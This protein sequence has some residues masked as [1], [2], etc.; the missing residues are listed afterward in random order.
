[1]SHSHHHTH[2]HQAESNLKTAFWLNA[3]FAIIEI[4]G[5]IYTNSIAI[6]SDAFHDLGDSAALGLAWYFQR[7]SSK[8]RDANYSYGYKRFS[9]AGAVSSS[10]IL[11]LGSV[12]IISEA[13]PRLFAP[14]I[15]N[16]K[17]M[18]LLAVIGIAVNSAAMFKLKKGRSQNEKMI[19]LHLLEDVLGWVAVLVAGIVM[20]IYEIPILDPLLSLLITLF[21]LYRAFGNIK[22]TLRIFMQ[23]TPSPEKVELLKNKLLEIEGI[24]DIHDLHI[25]TLDGSYN[26]ATLHI[27]VDPNSRLTDTEFIKSE[28]RNTLIHEGF[29]HS[30]IEIEPDGK[31]CE[32]I[33]C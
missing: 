25:W 5:G 30:T 11:I 23:A 31:L 4:A 33:N 18:L 13:I 24:T 28:V 6:L 17:G 10:A 21:I 1:M 7:Y 19:S 2:E 12:Y 22:Q 26:I 32:L 15:V 14:E 3:L 27:S 29:E 8:K 20:H 16:T 9:L